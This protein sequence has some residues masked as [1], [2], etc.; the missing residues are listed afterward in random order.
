MNGLSSDKFNLNY[1]VYQGN[2][3]LPLLYT[4]SLEPFLRKINTSIKGLYINNSYLKTR[5]F[6]DDIV[7]ALDDS[8]WSQFKRLIALYEISSN[9]KINNKKSKLIIFSNITTPFFQQ[10]Y[11]FIP[12]NPTIPITFLEIN[13]INYK[14]NYYST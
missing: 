9:A 10:I 13:I 5:A 7:I 14:Y 8:D 2:S 12:S 1:E 4:I 11:P 3:L 6:A